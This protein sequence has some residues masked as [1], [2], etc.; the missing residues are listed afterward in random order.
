MLKVAVPSR[1]GSVDEHFGHCEEF[2]V[3][4]FDERNLLVDESVVPSTEGC[5]CKSGIA[6]VL[7]RAGVTRMVAGNMG[8]SAVRVLEAQGIAV[9]RGASGD[10]RSAAMA[11]VRGELSD[12]GAVCRAHGED[13]ECGR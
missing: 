3:F 13:R 5:G 11:F 1:D 9:S 4:G 7:A 6:A 12:S 2:M 8:E 10:A